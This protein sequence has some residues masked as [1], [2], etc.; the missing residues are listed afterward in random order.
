M[1]KEITQFHLPLT[2]FIP[3]KGRATPGKLHLQSSIAVTHYILAV[4]HLPAQEGWNPESTFS[5]SWIELGPPAHMNEYA[6]EPQTTQPTAIQ[7]DNVFN[8]T[9]RPT[10]LTRQTLCSTSYQTLFH[11]LIKT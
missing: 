3:R 9:T 8:V 4:P 10:V 2:R 11:D 1:L 5:A 6:S 7:T